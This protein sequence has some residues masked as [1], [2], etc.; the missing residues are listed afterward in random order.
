[1]SNDMIVGETAA[2]GSLQINEFLPLLADALLESLQLLTRMDTLLARESR[3]IT[4]DPEKCRL[5]VEGSPMTITALLPL[6]GYER[7][8]E[9]LS[10]FLASGERNVR[11]FLDRKLGRDLVEKALSPYQLTA[12]GYR[13]NGTD[14]EGK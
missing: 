1:M 14:S 10:E 13:R 9:I 12:L 5:Y 7:A 6:I 2:R 8:G 4:A 3:R 11:A